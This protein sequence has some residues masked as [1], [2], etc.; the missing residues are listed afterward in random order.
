MGA[1]DL[2]NGCPWSASSSEPAYCILTH[3]QQEIRTARGC[4][5]D[6]ARQTWKSPMRGS[7]KYVTLLGSF[8]IETDEIE[9]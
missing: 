4:L 3:R 7:G 8:G 5:A 2:C 1:V 6:L 9:R